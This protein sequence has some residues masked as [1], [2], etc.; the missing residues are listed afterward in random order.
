M[1]P[2]SEL[3]ASVTAFLK[4][5]A[6]AARLLEIEDTHFEGVPDL[7][8]AVLFAVAGLDRTLTKQVYQETPD[9]VDISVYD[10]NETARRNFEPGGAVAALLFSRGV[11][12][13]MAHRVAHAIWQ[14]GDHML[15][16]TLKSRASRAFATDIHPA[17]QIGAGLWLDHGLGFVV[18]ETCV[19]GKD[20]SI[21]HNVTLGSTLNDSGA[22]RHPIVQDG[23]VIGAGAI[24]L[25]HVTI[26]TNANVAAG[27]IVVKD[28]PPSTLVVGT[29]SREI[30]PAQISFSQNKDANQ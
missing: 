24:I 27:S 28:V 25:G 22:Q 21:W 5:N 4:E 3:V 12:A 6:V 7:A 14:S 10:I 20:V 19:I 8:A 17:A 1:Y 30:G 2:K 18:G 23:V 11:Q 16:L 9:L 29:K 15:A 26:G 13:I